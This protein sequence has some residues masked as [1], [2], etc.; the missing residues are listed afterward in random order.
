MESKTSSVHK[1]HFVNGELVVFI[2]FSLGK[3]KCMSLVI[4]NNKITKDSVFQFQLPKTCG[5]EKLTLSINKE[6]RSLSNSDLYQ[7][8]KELLSDYWNENPLLKAKMQEF[9]LNRALKYS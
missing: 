7:L 2:T 9:H 3:Y 6:L 5:G 4:K 8:Y 1:V